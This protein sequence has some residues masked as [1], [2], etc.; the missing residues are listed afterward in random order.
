MLSILHSPLQANNRWDR[1]P[2]LQHHILQEGVVVPFVCIGYIVKISTSAVGVFLI[3]I[4]RI[5]NLIYR[6]FVKEH[7]V[8]ILVVGIYIAILKSKEEIF[9]I[10]TV[11]D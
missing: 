9:Y 2:L 7:A 8:F 3:Q 6:M 5:H 1:Q 4:I 10:L 11:V